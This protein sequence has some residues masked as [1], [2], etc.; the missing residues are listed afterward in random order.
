[1][2]IENSARSTHLKLSKKEHPS[3]ANSIMLVSYR[4]PPSTAVCCGLKRQQKSPNQ[5]GKLLQNNNLPI[6][7]SER[8]RAILTKINSAAADPHQLR[9]LFYV[10][11]LSRSFI[12]ISSK[13]GTK[14]RH[15][16]TTES[17]P[18]ETTQTV[19]QT[20]KLPNGNFDPAR[21]GQGEKVESQRTKKKN[22]KKHPKSDSS[23]FLDH[24][25]LPFPYFRP[26]GSS[27]TVT[28]WFRSF[29]QS[30]PGWFGPLLMQRGN[31]GIEKKTRPLSKVIQKDPGCAIPGW[32]YGPGWIRIAHGASMCVCVEQSPEKSEI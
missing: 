19:E 22:N 24:Y 20:N 15:K 8:A 1:M 16:N 14:T 7:T 13:K 6:G 30:S 32:F 11:K 12:F 10:K 18:S 9:V 23:V 5:V 27:G 2:V 31:D 4:S 17:P 25:Q 28:V 26:P 3:L 29:F 21:R